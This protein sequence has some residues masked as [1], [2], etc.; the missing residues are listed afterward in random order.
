MVNTKE[1]GMAVMTISKEETDAASNTYR[2][3][4]T[5]SIGW[6]RQNEFEVSEAEVDTYSETSA[7]LPRTVSNTAR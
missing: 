5:W 4:Y 3:L 6:V 7:A 1:P 2:L